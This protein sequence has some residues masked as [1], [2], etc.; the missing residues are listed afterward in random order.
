MSHTNQLQKINQRHT[1][2]IIKLTQTTNKNRERK[3]TSST[4]TT[5]PTSGITIAL[6]K[7]YKNKTNVVVS[8][9]VTHKCSRK[10][11][12]TCTSTTWKKNKIEKKMR[13]YIMLNRCSSVSRALYHVYKGFR[14]NSEQWCLNNWKITKC[15]WNLDF[16][17][18]SKY[19]DPSQ[20]QRANL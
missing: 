3:L 18:K 9:P 10:S 20:R 5:I 19:F 13:Y 7:T 4:T 17:W 14:C 2:K 1:T 6:Y 12:E 15:Y 11:V 8:L 16:N